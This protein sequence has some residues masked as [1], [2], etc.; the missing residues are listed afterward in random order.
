LPPP[1][2]LRLDY[3]HYWGDPADSFHSMKARG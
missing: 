1:R 2:A 3:A